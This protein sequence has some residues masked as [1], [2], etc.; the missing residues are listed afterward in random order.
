MQCVL[1]GRVHLGN[2][3]ILADSVRVSGQGQ[4]RFALPLVGLC[5]IVS[6]RRPK[7]IELDGLVEFLDRIGQFGIRQLGLT[8]AGIHQGARTV[9][10]R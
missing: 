2:F 10:L 8:L 9:P 1:F 4:L 6:G 7:R 3:V 5:P